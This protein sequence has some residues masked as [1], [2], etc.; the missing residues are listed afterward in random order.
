MT[1]ASLT[2]LDGLEQVST[3]FQSLERS[4]HV[5]IPVGVV[6]KKVRAMVGAFVSSLVAR[7]GSRSVRILGSL[8]MR[9]GCISRRREITCL[10]GEDAHTVGTSD[11]YRG[12]PAPDGAGRSGTRAFM[13]SP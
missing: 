10:V 12:P 13:I 11:T 4:W 1:S 5:G 2:I 6:K 7:G 3:V 9:H 8:P